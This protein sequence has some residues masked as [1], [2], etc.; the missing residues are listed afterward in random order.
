M[1][2]EGELMTLQINLT[3]SELGEHMLAC[4]KCRDKFYDIVM[5]MSNVDN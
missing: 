1:L 3:L 4:K 5:H 2:C